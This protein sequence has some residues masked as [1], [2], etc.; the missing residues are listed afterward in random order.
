MSALCLLRRQGTKTVA[1]AVCFAYNIA[2]SPHHRNTDRAAGLILH[3]R[4]ENT[5]GR[6]ILLL[7]QG[8][9]PI[10]KEKSVSHTRPVCLQSTSFLGY[11]TTFH[12]FQKTE[13][14]I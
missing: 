9:P 11:L 1:C 5:E 2:F 8:V 12:L 10:K 7:S 4:E 13:N 3:C 14:Q 6:E